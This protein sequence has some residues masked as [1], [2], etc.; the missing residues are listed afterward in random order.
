[1]QPSSQP[2]SPPTS[3]PSSQPS[4]RPSTALD[5]DCPEGTYYILHPQYYECILCSPGYFTNAFNTSTCQS[6]PLNSYADSFGATACKPCPSGYVSGNKASTSESD[7]VN[8]IINFSFGIIS[9]F[10]SFLAVF[11]YI[12]LGRVQRIAFERRRWLVEKCMILYGIVLKVVDEA[13]CV[14][15]AV[16]ILKRIL[17]SEHGEDQSG[18]L[19]QLLKWGSFVLFA[20]LV[21]VVIIAETIFVATIHVLGNALLLYRAYRSEG[22]FLS[23]GDG[24][25]VFINRINDFLFAIGR[26]LTINSFIDSI[27]YHVRMCSIS[28]HSI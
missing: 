25:A 16:E 18:F 10:L 21:A 14:V 9:L 12:I 2:H 26:T 27:A 6:C 24:N 28:W 3:Q 19:S 11:V 20:I 8:P 22:G 23:S 13:K 7:C 1:M 17:K 15:K 5:P 4:T